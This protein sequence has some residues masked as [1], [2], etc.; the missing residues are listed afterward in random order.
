MKQITLGTRVVTRNGPPYIIAE[1]GHNHGGSIETAEMLVRKAALCEVDGVKLQKRDNANLYTQ[2]RANRPHPDRKHGF[3]ETYLAHREFLEFGAAEYNRL[4]RLA[5]ELGVDFF[6][7]AFDEASVDFLEEVGVGIYKVASGDVTNVQLLDYIAR[8]GKPM[9]VST[10]ACTV[11]EI[12]LAYDT[13]LRHHDQ[14]VLLHCVAKYPT[15]MQ[16]VNLMRIKKLEQEFPDALIGY[17]GHDHGTLA[18]VIASTLGAVVFEKHFTHD[19]GAKGTDHGFSLDIPE[20]YK[21][22]QELR[23]VPVALGNPD[24]ELQTFEWDARRSMG[25]SLYLA[26][27]QKAGHVLKAEDIVRKSPGGGLPPY[28]LDEIIGRQLAVDLEE[29]ALLSIDQLVPASVATR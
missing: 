26:H 5:K 12:R 8:L 13:V 14:L 22:V 19:H 18:P 24:V 21:Q 7:T 17:S 29:E 6:A 25:K 4:K 2:E 9:I 27:A 28:K 15:K 16:D 11:D 23:D 3:G 20:M 10:G 1:I